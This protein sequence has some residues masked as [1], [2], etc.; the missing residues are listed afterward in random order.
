M[1][2]SLLGTTLFETLGFTYLG[3]VDGHDVEKVTEILRTAVA[4]HEPVIVH[5]ITQKGKGYV[6]AE[7]GPQKFHGI[8]KFDPDS[9]KA[10]KAGAETFS[11][12]FG[13]ELTALAR[14]DSRVCAITAAMEYGTGL[15]HFA[16][17]LP[18]RFFDVG[19]AE[20]HAI[21]M[22]AGMA[23]QGMIPVA[24]IYSTFLQRSFDMLLHDVALQQLHVVLAV[25]RA[26]L[27]GEDGR[28]APRDVRRGISAACTGD[29]GILSREFCRAAKDAPRGG[30][31][32]QRAGRDT[33]SARRRRETIFGRSDGNAH[34]R[35]RGLHAGLLRHDRGGCAGGCGPV[36][37]KG[38]F[39]GDFEAGTGWR[40]WT[41]TLWRDPSGRR[42]GSSW[43]RR[44][45]T[46]GALR[47][48]CSRG[49]GRRRS[50]LSGKREIWAGDS[51]RTARP[52][53][54]CGRPDWT[55]MELSD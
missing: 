23:K 28:D 9:G 18:N 34:P 44:R 37:R 43:R 14:E 36:R 3:P 55:R 42:G 20:E 53:S 6:P 13:K 19:I 52:R 47:T 30:P 29:A 46:G 32:V 15:N 25:D 51:S 26:G 48:S 39:C 22:A 41:L 35:G 11:D 4:L 33:L 16:D 49:S 31:G 17:A 40:R 27:V 8:G 21:S 24:A 12:V 2:R 45:L 10:L 1:R 7:Q 50:H 54:Y 5:L 38:R